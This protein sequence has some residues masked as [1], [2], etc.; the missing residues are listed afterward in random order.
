MFSHYD[1]VE[2]TRK[3]RKEHDLM[4]L[5][6]DDL[7]QGEEQLTLDEM[8]PYVYPHDKELSAVGVR[9][10]YLN[11]YFR[12]DSKAQHERMIR[13]YGYETARQ[14]RTFDSY[15]DVDCAHYSGLHDYIKFLKWGYGKATDH[16]CREIRLKRMTRREGIRN[17]EIYHERYSEEDL[18]L[19]LDWIGWSEEQLFECVDRHRD[20]EIWERDDAGGWRLLDSVANHARDEGVDS[21]RL[22]VRRD[23]EFHLTGAR[24]EAGEDTGGY[25]LIGRGFVDDADSRGW[26][27]TRA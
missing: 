16:S 4:G 5:E 1:E 11:N 13:E 14:Q 7:V 10:I 18:G 22:D 26:K 25:I 15:N 27:P 23:C 3:Y 20:P 21:A 9:G 6:A 12:W 19:F 2:M 8:E 17:A 24:Q